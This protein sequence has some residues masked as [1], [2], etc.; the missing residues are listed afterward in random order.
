MPI[1]PLPPLKSLI[2]FE[3]AARHSNFTAAAL[4]LNV[5]QGAISRQIRQLEDYLGHPL[6]VRGQRSTTLT[7]VG[8]QYCAA[9]RKSLGEISEATADLIQWQG[10]QQFTVA[11]T[12]AM[13]SYWLLPKFAEFQSLYPEVEA[14]ILA[15]DSLR[16]MRQSEFDVGLFYYRSAPTDMKSTPLFNE[17]VFPVCSPEYLEAHPELKEPQALINA[18]LLYLDNKEDWVNW[19]E[20]FTTCGFDLPKKPLKRSKI[21][22]YTLVMQ[23]ALNGQGVALG[24]ETLVDDYLSSGRLV[25]PVQ[26]SMISSAQFFLLEPG[27]S[28]SRKEGVQAFCDWLL[29]QK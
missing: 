10:D 17:H 21:N 15:I 24:W 5:T 20:W 12:G 16:N 3:A 2:A 23:A 8:E 28:S 18:T 27:H 19:E 7:D 9:V 4:E 14:R 6:F 11:I 26:T 29:E 1:Q 25:R 22:N 13:A